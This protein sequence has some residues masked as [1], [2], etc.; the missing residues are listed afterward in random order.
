MSRWLVRP[1]HIMCTCDKCDN[2]IHKAVELRHHGLRLIPLYQRNA[3]E[4]TWCDFHNEEHYG[5]EEC[6][7]KFPKKECVE[8]RCPECGIQKLKEEIN[9]VVTP[10]FKEKI[11]TWFTLEKC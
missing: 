9:S 5:N 6:R 7:K 1:P 11:T 2:Q 10:E 3:M 8:R 4:K